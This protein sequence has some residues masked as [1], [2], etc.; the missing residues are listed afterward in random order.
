MHQIP[1][2]LY[3]AVRIDNQSS[4]KVVAPLMAFIPPTPRLSLFLNRL[5]DQ[6]NSPE[7]FEYVRAYYPTLSNWLDR[8]ER[9]LSRKYA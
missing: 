9:E 5:N 3:T 2:H 6:E 4:Q 7:L 1:L 8:N